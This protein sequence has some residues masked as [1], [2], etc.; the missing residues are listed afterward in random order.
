MTVEAE[1]LSIV[2]EGADDYRV[3]CTSTATKLDLTPRETPRSVSVVARAQIEDF[4][5][6]TIN[7]VLES[8]PPGGDG[9]TAG[10]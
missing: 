4:N 3:S 8:T 2:P 10:D 7:D 1:A 5:P 6:H 9:G